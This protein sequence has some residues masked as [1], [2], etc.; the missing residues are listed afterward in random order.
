MIKKKK[1][2]A[3]RKEPTGYHS[4]EGPQQSKPNRQE[5]KI[6]A[7]TMEFVDLEKAL[8]EYESLEDL[9]KRFLAFLDT[10]GLEIAVASDDVTVP[11]R[12]L[13]FHSRLS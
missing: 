6:Q 3:P 10:R 1:P 11:Y 7:A 2:E 9:L 5:K 4:P 12:F 8:D 13:A